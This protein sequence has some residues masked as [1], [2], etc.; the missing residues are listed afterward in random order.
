MLSVG[1]VVVDGR[2][3]LN[4]HAQTQTR[5]VDKPFSMLQHLV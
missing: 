2:F 4:T 1:T 3:V 5:T